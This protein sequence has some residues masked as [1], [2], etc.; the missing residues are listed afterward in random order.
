MSIKVSGLAHCS[1]FCSWGDREGVCVVPPDNSSSFYTWNNFKYFT[2]TELGI[3]AV[4][5]RL[6]HTR[7]KIWELCGVISDFLQLSMGHLTNE[8]WLLLYSIRFLLWLQSGFFC[9]WLHVLRQRSL[10]NG[11]DLNSVHCRGLHIN[12]LL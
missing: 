8:Q 1:Y 7:I 12:F 5:F 4:F 9:I 6:L 11:V 10:C 2:G 3:V